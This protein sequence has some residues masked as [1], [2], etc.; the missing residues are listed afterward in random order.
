MVRVPEPFGSENHEEDLARWQ[1]FQV[2][3]RAWLYYGN[4]L[5]EEDLHRTELHGAAPIPAIAGEPEEVQQRCKL[6]SILTGLLSWKT[7]S[8]SASGDRA[9]WA[10]GLETVG[11]AVPQD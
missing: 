9:Q 7:A 10:R 1:D 3:F 11:S 4:P 6:H 5:F 8:V 2:N